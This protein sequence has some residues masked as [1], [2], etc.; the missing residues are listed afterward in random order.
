MDLQKISNFTSGP[1]KGGCQE[2]PKLNLII[3]IDPMATVVATLCKS[4]L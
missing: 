2:K 3:I 1:I 4:L